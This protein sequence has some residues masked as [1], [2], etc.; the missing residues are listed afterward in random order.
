MHSVGYIFYKKA[1]WRAGR[2][3]KTADCML[4]RLQTD[5]LIKLERIWDT[6]VRLF[7]VVVAR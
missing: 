4:F 1:E 7:V 6:V 5:S 2:E 3:C